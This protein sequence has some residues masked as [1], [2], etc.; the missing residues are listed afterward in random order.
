MSELIRES[1]EAHTLSF[2][3]ANVTVTISPN[4][5]VSV[6]IIS[7]DDAAPLW[8]AVTFNDDSTNAGQTLRVLI[9]DESRGE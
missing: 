4:G 5:D 7:L 8:V 9:R 2:E 1:I 6:N 3:D